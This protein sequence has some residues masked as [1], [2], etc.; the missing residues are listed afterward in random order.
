MKRFSP[1]STFRTLLCALWVSVTVAGYGQTLGEI[2]GHLT[3]ATGASLPGAAI[4]LTSISTGA[5][6]AAISTD[7]GD[8]SL[9]SVPPGIYRV[10]WNTR[11][12]KPQSGTMS[13]S[14]C[15]KPYVWTSPCK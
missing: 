3:D 12:S 8:Y 1:S 13:K 14:R 15:N 4:T 11:V 5:V 7:A 6:R 2:T 9:P 10:K